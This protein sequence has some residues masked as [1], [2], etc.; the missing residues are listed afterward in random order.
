MKVIC[1]C[2]KP[3]AIDL[4]RVNYLS[5]SQIIRKSADASIF[6]NLLSVRSQSM[7]NKYHQ[8]STNIVIL[9]LSIKVSVI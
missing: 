5:D 9:I 2:A 6:C 8:N 1:T 7:N 4:E 3:S